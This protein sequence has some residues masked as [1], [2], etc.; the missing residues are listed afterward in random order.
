MAAE[1]LQIEHHLRQVFVLEFATLSLVSYGPVL[2]EYAAEVAIGEKNSAGTVLA[3]QRDLFAEM[4][5]ANINYNFPRGSTEAAFAFQS[6]CPTLSG[7]KLAL[8]QKGIGLLDPW[9]Q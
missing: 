1:V 4:R 2:T 8:P 5:L 7:T 3:H 6:I 9:S